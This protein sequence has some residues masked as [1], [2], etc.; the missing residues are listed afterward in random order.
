MKKIR[1]GIIGVGNIGTA[2]A[3][4]IYDGKIEG[5]ELSALCD[6][7]EKRLDSL[8]L[9]FPNIPLFKSSDELISSG[10]CDAVVIATP[11]YFH[12]P[13]SRVALE[14]NLDVLCEKPLGV[15]TKGIKELFS[16]A[17]KNGRVFSAMLNQRANKLF[18]KAR[19]LITTGKIG[20]IKRSVW[21][22]TNWYRTEAYY[23][24]GKWRGTWQGEGGGVLMNQ[25]PHN[26]DLWQWLCGMPRS[27]YA[28]C[29]SGKYHDI[30]VEDEATIFAEY[31]NGATGVFITSTGDY[32][33]TNRLEIIG[34]CG[35]LVL[36]KGTLTFTS[37]SCS[38]RELCSG[39]TDSIEEA[40]EIIEDEEYNGHRVIL[41]NF[42]NAILNGEELIAPASEAI[43][44]LMICNLSYLSSWKGE[45]IELPI[46]ED[47]YLNQLEERIKSSV[48][49]NSKGE[50]SFGKTYL[51]RWQTNW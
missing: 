51:N 1:V 30:E 34:E 31:E 46:N 38:E 5:L 19:E 2:H 25:A 4:S 40:V 41:Q 8:R 50:N 45:K 26:L 20:K 39:K 49:K 42:A 29:N 27:I 3:Y 36:E 17:D 37:F 7:D 22:I 9:E 24:S 28:I 47:E 32:D 6:V 16:L 14:N 48:A 12:V 35:K 43:N 21:I 11:H 44:E 13:I 33:G 15:Y 23:S 18:K 10:I